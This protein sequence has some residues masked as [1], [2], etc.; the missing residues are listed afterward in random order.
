MWSSAA[1][2]LEGA[3]TKTNHDWSSAADLLTQTIATHL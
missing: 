3:K 2:E 1:T